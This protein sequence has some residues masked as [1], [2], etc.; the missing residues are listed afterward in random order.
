MHAAQHDLI[1]QLYADAACNLHKV[2]TKPT[3]IGVL[4]TRDPRTRCSFSGNEWISGVM[5]WHAAV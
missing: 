3:Q 1:G 4:A 5:N 2:E